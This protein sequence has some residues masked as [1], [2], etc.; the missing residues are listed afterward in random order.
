MNKI[1]S[2][3][4]TII[5]L[6][7]LSQNVIAQHGEFPKIWVKDTDKQR[8]LDNIDNYTWAADLYQ[9]LLDHVEAE[10]DTHLVNPE[11]Y[12]SRIPLTWG[13][14]NYIKYEGGSLAAGG[15]NYSGTSPF[16][17]LHRVVEGLPKSPSGAD[18]WYPTLEEIPP[19]NT[20]PQFGMEMR[21][22]PNG[23]LEFVPYLG[24]YL[25]HIHVKFMTLGVDAGIAY[26]L[27][28]DEKYAQ[29]AADILR[30]YV[31][32]LRTM[33]R[34]IGNQ[35]QGG[36]LIP[37]NYLRESRYISRIPLMYDFIQPWLAD[38][39]NNKV[40][41]P[42]TGT[43]SAFRED[44]AQHWFVKQAETTAAVGATALSNWDIL[45][46]ESAWFP[47]MCI[48]DT[49]LSDSLFINFH[50]GHPDLPGGKYARQMPVTTMFGAIVDGVWPESSG[51]SGGV[52]SDLGIQLNILDM[53]KPELNFVKDN[54]HIL[55]AQ[56]TLKET[57]FP[58]DERMRYGDG[59][60]SAV[61]VTPNFA[62]AYHMALRNDLE[63]EIAYFG[64]A[65]KN[66]L[67]T[68]SRG[69]WGWDHWELFYHRPLALLWGHD[70]DTLEAAPFEFKS[71]A[72]FYDVGIAF[73][74]NY[75]VED[76][77]MHGLMAHSGG[78]GGVHMFA[79]GISI[80]LY[81][82]GDVLGQH[83]GFR[84]G[85]PIH[86]DYE[87]RH[88]AHNTVTIN[89]RTNRGVSGAWWNMDR[90]MTLAMEPNATEVPLSENFTFTYQHLDDKINSATQERTL[91]IIRT[92]DTTGYYLDFFRSIDLN[93]ND[94]HDYIY[95]N[96]CDTLEITKA[97]NDTIGLT[98]DTERYSENKYGR[99][100]MDWFW[101]AKTGTHDSTV[102]ARFHMYEGDK[103]MHVKIPA[104]NDLE[105]TNAMAPSLD[106]APFHYGDEP[107][108]VLVVRKLGEAWDDPFV[109]VFEPSLN[110]TGT[111]KSIEKLKV[112]GKVVGAIVKSEVNGVEIEDIVI[113][114]DGD[115][116]V[117]LL[118]GDAIVFDGTFAII[119][120]VADT[121][122]TGEITLYIGEGNSLTYNGTTLNSDA[123]NQGLLTFSGNTKS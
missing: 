8:I 44:F 123:N 122:S 81:G 43:Y 37:E 48:S 79:S 75:Y 121:D 97:N 9:G 65:L 15:V 21:T 86:E 89:G 28:G 58:N 45:M 110:E 4:V 11:F 60:R 94:Y 87:M 106:G 104:G 77:L 69:T 92:S 93:T 16:H 80:E 78:A 103:Y 22:K 109:T 53:Y 107:T 105:F 101:D 3:A 36:I 18:M 63:D 27:T 72:S 1:Q 12:T 19:F 35:I 91:S 76:T 52:V 117:S 14:E 61:S 67:K 23:D 56:R 71:T 24:D 102:H 120:K 98:L 54:V 84:R 108:Q 5:A 55:D 83:G 68:Y 31:G 100:G 85:K 64:T 39:A 40:Y 88:A 46:A 74:R 116:E 57:S 82:V 6:I 41:D 20:D 66:E 30:G 10:A 118:F 42:E 113:S 47:V 99:S 17:T 49:V 96:I 115:K 119:R 38:T 73:Q 59:N 2:I 25:R 33:S 112:D 13:G 29:L 50:V 26:W 7:T 95:H 51:Y 111:V 62:R 90:T 114:Q 32:G 34:A 70:V